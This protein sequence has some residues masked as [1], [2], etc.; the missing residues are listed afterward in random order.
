L[1]KE[2]SQGRGATKT[3]AK[4]NRPYAKEAPTNLMQKQTEET[5]AKGKRSQVEKP[6]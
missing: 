5:G 3:G 1:K 2:G 6:S 4:E